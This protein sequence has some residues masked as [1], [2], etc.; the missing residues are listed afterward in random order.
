MEVCAVDHQESNTNKHNLASNSIYMFWCY[1]MTLYN[2]SDCGKNSAGKYG[3]DTSG[4]ES[5][6]KLSLRPEYHNVS[7]YEIF[8]KYCIPDR[9]PKRP[10]SDQC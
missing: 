5:Y 4:R 6:S 10:V 1:R 9:S 2:V 3:L 7:S 8:Y